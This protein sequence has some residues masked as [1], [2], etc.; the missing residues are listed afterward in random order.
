MSKEELINEV[1]VLRAFI[2][3]AAPRHW[4]DEYK[5]EA[6]TEWE[7]EAISVLHLESISKD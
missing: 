2:M 3:A 1:M 6:A 4:V 7:R 5:W